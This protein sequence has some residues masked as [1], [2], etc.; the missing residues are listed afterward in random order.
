MPTITPN[1]PLV[2]DPALISAS[3]GEEIAMLHVESGRYFFL[4]GV[5]AAIWE[6]LEEATTPADLCAALV[7]RYDV[8]PAQCETEVLSLLGTL[9][10]K[11]MI[12]VAR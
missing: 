3:L 10:D 8:S 2:R 4:N 1:T 12:H 6:R 5:A 11:E 7:E 9:L